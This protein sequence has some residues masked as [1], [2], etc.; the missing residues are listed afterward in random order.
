MAESRLNLEIIGKDKA[1]GAFNSVSRALDS[2]SK[3]VSGIPIIGQKAS[4][5][6]SSLSASLGG[7]SGLATAAAAAG[8]AVAAAGAA[9]AKGLLDSATGY[10]DAV[11]EIEDF[12]N[13]TGM[14]AESASRFVA[15]ADD[16]GLSANT[17][18]TAFSKLVR[19]QA[20]LSSLGLDVDVSN[21]E[22]AFLAIAD[23]VASIEDPVL[24][25]QIA[26]AAFGRAGKE[27]FPLLVQGSEDFKAALEDVPL[28]Q[29]FNTEDIEKAK[30]LR[31][32][33][34]AVGDSL[35]GVSNMV[36]ETVAPVITDLAN[37]FAILIGQI[38][39]IAKTK[40]G[41]W[42][43]LKP[44]ELAD[45]LSEAAERGRE[46]AIETIRATRSEAQRK[47]TI[48]QL[49]GAMED[50]TASQESLTSA[51][52]SHEKATLDVTVAELS[53]AKA[54][55][56]LSELEAEGAV[57]E[58][59]VARSRERLA[60][61]TRGV[62]DAE[63]RLGDARKRLNDLLTPTA[64]DAEDLS[65]RRAKA[66]QEIVKA[67]N[68]L[69]AVR[70]AG[71]SPI[72]M[73]EAELALRDARLDLARTDED[74]TAKAE[75]IEDARRDVA[76]AETNLARSKDEV[77]RAGD[78]LRRAEAGDPDFALKLAQARQGVAE[79]ESRLSKSHLA[80]RDAMQ[81]EREEAERLR[82]K[83]Q[84]LIDQATANSWLFGGLDLSNLSGGG[85]MGRAAQIG[86]Q[87][88]AS[89]TS[90]THIYDVDVT[91]A[92]AVDIADAIN[93]Q[94]RLHNLVGGP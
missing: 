9:A 14:S 75:D 3:K 39:E 56:E 11:K 91:S 29:I 24:K 44:W 69:N 72:A 13:V 74:A 37:G 65:L 85:I 30:E 6:M 79:A 47:R 57:N 66:Q 76:D 84:E 15:V 94:Q 59:Q 82:L 63:D 2:L 31:L 86:Q 55:R 7:P 1:S 20:A 43:A 21:P 38:S 58:E 34:D 5:A 68:R 41:V 17:L 35:R 89:S 28:A 23:A 40:P 73:T 50:E 54:Q 48:E 52:E 12:V 26:F 88:A 16:L 62:T 19:S 80:V 67:E 10:A 18:T 36:G 33:T 25:N 27:L 70:E 45:E 64:T 46:N 22:Q 93:R 71:G 92:D 81:A 61:A 51:T 42:D 4:G 83:R 8:T 49:R 78:E 32:A 60:D 77:K 53:L 90:V 87:A